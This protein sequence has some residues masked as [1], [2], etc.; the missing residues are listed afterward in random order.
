MLRLESCGIRSGSFVLNADLQVPAGGSYAVIG[1]SGAGKS[2]L[3]EV[4]AG[5]RDLSAGAIYWKEQSLSDLS[6]GK[7]PIASL[8]QDGNLFPHLSAQQNVA[9]GLGKNGRLSR[10]EQDQ[11]NS[12]LSRVGLS[13]MNGRKP[14]EM[15]GG[16][17]SRVA[18]ARVLVQQRELLLLDEPFS[19][20]GPALK[21]KM[22][23]LVRDL[24]EETG[25]TLIMVS[26]DPKD[27][28]RIANQTIYVAEG[29][30]HEPIDTSQFLDDPPSSVKDYF[31]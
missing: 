22:L 1:H 29:K 30:V 23:D 28:R 8:F 10:D 3:L 24:V 31:E 14:R 19:A 16:Q 21:S 17:Q 6:P 18:L 15:S 4:I 13:D 5:F 27:A 20:L 11:V 9:L 26:H 7:R 25:T 2:T 12:A